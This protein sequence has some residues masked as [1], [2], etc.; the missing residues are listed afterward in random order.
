MMTEA[1]RADYQRAA[2]ALENGEDELRSI[3][4]EV[5]M[6]AIVMAELLVP[7][8]DGPDSDAAAIDNK[9]AGLLRECIEKGEPLP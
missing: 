5:A 9:A 2:V 7:H 1:E 4:G 8:G 6:R 3:W